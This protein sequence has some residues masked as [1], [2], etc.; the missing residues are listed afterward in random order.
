MT[1]QELINQ[2]RN[3]PKAIEFNQ[4]I[5]TINANYSYAPTKFTNGSV[6]N[7]AGTNEGSC[8]V[9]AF[10]QLNGLSEEET[11]NCFAEHYRS[12]LDDPDGDAHANIRSFMAE[13][14]D[15]INFDGEALQG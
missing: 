2:L 4:V 11:L 5:E 12:V 1:V 13:G 9:F 14:W 15:G 6:V 3:A 7:E 8:K 10:G